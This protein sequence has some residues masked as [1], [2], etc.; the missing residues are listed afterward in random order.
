MTIT[1]CPALSLS[2]SRVALGMTTWNFGDSVTVSVTQPFTSIKCMH[3]GSDY[4]FDAPAPDLR[5]PV[6]GFQFPDARHFAL[7]CNGEGKEPELISANPLKQLVP[8]VWIE[9]TTYRLQGGCS[10]TE[11]KRLGGVSQAIIIATAY[12]YAPPPESGAVESKLG[13]TPS[14]QCVKFSSQGGRYGDEAAYGVDYNQRDQV[15]IG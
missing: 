15:Y 4:R 12:A 11:L 2:N 10:T 6:A 7:E 13:Q 1:F 3:E 5:L 9:Q 14:L 8:L